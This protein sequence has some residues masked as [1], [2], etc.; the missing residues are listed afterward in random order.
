MK[1]T[2]LSRSFENPCARCYQTLVCFVCYFDDD[3]RARLRNHTEMLCSPCVDAEV[4]Y[5]RGVV[6]QVVDE[7]GTAPLTRDELQKLIAAG[8]DE[9]RAG[10]GRR[11]RVTVAPLIK[12]TCHRP[13][14]AVEVDPKFLA[15]RPHWF[16]LLRGAPEIA[17]DVKQF[18]RPGQEIDKRPSAEYLAAFERAQQ[19]WG[20]KDAARAA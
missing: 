2:I 15:C 17:R 1:L 10:L 4:A 16:E 13:G 5:T 9:A 11:A 8:A 12:H 6:G 19:W 14:C 18:Y 20:E 7:R 3:R